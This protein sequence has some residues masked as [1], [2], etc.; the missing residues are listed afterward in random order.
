MK[1]LSFPCSMIP[2]YFNSFFHSLNSLQCP[3]VNSQCTLS[4]T[5]EGKH[6]NPLEQAEGCTR[7]GG[8]CYPSTIPPSGQAQAQGIRLLSILPW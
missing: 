7:R 8:S 6:K 2:Y 4:N 3:L 5:F 1:G